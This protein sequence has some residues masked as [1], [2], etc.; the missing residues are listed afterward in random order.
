M[1]NFLSDRKLSNESYGS[2]YF[3]FYES[4]LQRTDNRALSKYPSVAAEQFHRR[5]LKETLD[6][7]KS[8]DIFNLLNPLVT[9]QAYH[10]LNQ[11]PLHA[12]NHHNGGMAK[13]SGSIS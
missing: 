11:Q 7:Q 13:S 1:W 8:E 5:R 9:L 4:K 6:H 10:P 3:G 2:G 12:V